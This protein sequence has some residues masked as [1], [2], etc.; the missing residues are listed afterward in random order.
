MSNLR[1]SVQLIGNLGKDPEIKVLESGKK[2]ARLSVATSDAF[3][4]AHG[5]TV[6]NTQWHRVVAF[7]KLAEIIEQ[8]LD[9]GKELALEG[10]LVHRTYEDS[11]GITRYTTEIIANEMVM[12]GK[13]LTND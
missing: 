4:N 6:Q 7:G 13:K 10:K 1:N 2:V 5:Q 8:F 3:K 11:E 9:K 12:L